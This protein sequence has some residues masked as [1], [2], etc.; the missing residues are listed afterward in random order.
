MAATQDKGDYLVAAR[1]N[2]NAL[3]FIKL[4]MV[5]E[6]AQKIRRY[7]SNVYRYGPGAKTICELKLKAKFAG[8]LT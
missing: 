5:Q 7:Y 3:S 1:L 6:A 2:V 8:I 4:E